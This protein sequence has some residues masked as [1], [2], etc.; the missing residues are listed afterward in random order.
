MANANKQIKTKTINERIS[1]TDSVL[2][3]LQS[4]IAALETVIANMQKT[5]LDFI[6][7][8]EQ[9]NQQVL[10][11]VQKLENHAALTSNRLQTLEEQVGLK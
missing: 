7:K 4:K 8:Q 11:E 10:G 6:Q 9:A 1:D 5:Q 2:E 3:K